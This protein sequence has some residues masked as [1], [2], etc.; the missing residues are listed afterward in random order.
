MVVFHVSTFILLAQLSRGFRYT[1]KK[2][3]SQESCFMAFTYIIDAIVFLLFLTN[4][5]GVSI[6]A[7]IDAI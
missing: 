5:I 6:G 3:L 1:K 2:Q 7:K 4:F